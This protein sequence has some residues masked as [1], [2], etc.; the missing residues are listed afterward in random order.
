MVPT[1]L[2]IGAALAAVAAVIVVRFLPARESVAEAD[3]L[4][5]PVSALAEADRAA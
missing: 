3:A 4:E 5:T 1:G 2:L